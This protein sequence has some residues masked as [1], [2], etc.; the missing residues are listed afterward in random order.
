MEGWN[1]WMS[2]FRVAMKRAMSR[3]QVLVSPDLDAGLFA[4]SS[5]AAAAPGAGLCI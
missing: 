2:R 3:R 5:P 1:G 4:T